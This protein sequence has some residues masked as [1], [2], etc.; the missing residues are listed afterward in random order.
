M[1]P[2][3][4]QR[5]TR[6]LDLQH[7]PEALRAAALEHARPLELSLDGARAW[8]TRSDNPPGT[9]FLAKLLGRRSNSVDPDPW[10]ETLIVLH[11][12]HLLIAT[13]GP[14]RGTTALS[15]LLSRATLKR[16]SAFAARGTA[17]PSDD[18]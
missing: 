14:Q 1:A 10:H 7:A 6:S 16:G 4:Y 2:P 5:S 8:L 13:T 9:G 15:I 12:S 17:A 3:L 18:G 11:A